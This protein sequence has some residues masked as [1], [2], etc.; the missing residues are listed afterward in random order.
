MKRV[1]LIFLALV[2]LVSGL[3]ALQI[4]T[5]IP[6]F[7]MEI[8]LLEYCLRFL[9]IAFFVVIFLYLFK[10]KSKRTKVGIEEQEAKK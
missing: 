3:E 6:K 1:T 10:L 4:S 8:M 2:A 5:M 7:Y 9:I